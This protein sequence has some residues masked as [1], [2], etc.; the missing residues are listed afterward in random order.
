MVAAGAAQA[1]QGG[2]QAGWSRRDSRRARTAVGELG[3]AVRLDRTPRRGAD[4]HPGTG[5]RG[6]RSRTDGAEPARARRPFRRAAARRG[7]GRDPADGR[8]AR[9]A[10]RG[11]RGRRTRAPRPR[12]QRPGCERHRPRVDR[13]R[14]EPGTGCGARAP[15]GWPA[16]AAARG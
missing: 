6:P 12:G 5:D 2:A 16:R 14:A 4:A 15:A 7:W 3:C 8:P 13:A 1:R 9:T 10:A 11:A